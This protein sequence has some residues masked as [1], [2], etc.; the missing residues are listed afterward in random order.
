MNKVVFDLEA[1]GL[2][3]DKIHCLAM[4]NVNTRKARSTTDYDHIHAFCQHEDWWYIGHNIQLYDVPALETILR[5]AVKGRLVDTLALSWY[6]YPNRLKHGLEEWGEEF[7]IKKPEITDW[8][9][10]TEAEYVHRCEQ[11]VQ[12]NLRLWDKI[13]A[14]LIKLYGSESEAIRILDYLAFKMDCVREQ[15]LYGWKLD[16][17]KAE[18]L[19]QSL[20]Q[21]QGEKVAELVKVMPRKPI[22]AIRKKPGKPY[23]MDGSL[24]VAG[25]EWFE[26]LAYMDLPMDHSEPVKFVKDYEDG[27]PNSAP[28][29]KEWLYSLGWEPTTFKYD[30]EEDGTVRKIPQI[31]QDKTKGPGLCESV[32]KLFDKCPDLKVL[33]G[34]SIINHRL[35]IVEGFLRDVDEEGYLKAQMAGFTNTLRLKHRTIVNLPGITTSYGEDIRGCL[36]CDSDQL[37]CGSD[38]SG[39]EDRL[40]QHFIYPFDP[41]YVRD[42]MV[43]D[44]DPH[45]DLALSAGAVDDKMVMIYK[46]TGDKTI[47]GI[48]HTYKQ[49]NYAC[50]YGAQPPRLALT[51]GCSLDKA[52]GV[53]DAYWKRNWAIHAAA[54]AQ[55][56]KEMYGQKWLFNPINHLWYSLRHD[57]DRFSTLVQGSASWCF[58]TWLRHVRNDGPPTIGQFHDEF[59][60]RIKQQHKERMREHVKEA[61]RLTNE[62]LQLNRELECDIKFGESYAAIH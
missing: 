6:L 9:N 25:K 19:R 48:R 15:E 24:S 30:R 8:E 47:K 34:L 5:T 16:K 22:Y 49:G 23:K 18:G 29:I 40:K 26:F 44:F 11:D 42:M 51:I 3:P 12:I 2:T 57:K 36:I 39:L 21:A 35:G 62:E 58:D 37:L 41:Q 17:E 38:L 60:G 31:Q 50:Q 10:L 32:K 33:D 4:V 28:Q 13:W 54:E 1:N 43:P 52:K 59:I 56:V 14:D 61:M 20:L 55:I 46:E 45:L 27:N 53:F 7:G